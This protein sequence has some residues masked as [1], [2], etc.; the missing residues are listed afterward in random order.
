VVA[1]DQLRLRSGRSVIGGWKLGLGLG[2]GLAEGLQIAGL[3]GLPVSV[4]RQGKPELWRL[5]E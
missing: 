3:L 2:L 4:Q 1:I 5:A